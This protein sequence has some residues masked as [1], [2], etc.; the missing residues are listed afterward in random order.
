MKTTQLASMKAKFFRLS[1][2]SFTALFGLFNAGVHAATLVFSDDF[3]TAN[4]AWQ[5]GLTDTQNNATA[6]SASYGKIESGLLQLKANVGPG[7]DY[8][9]SW[10]VLNQALPANYEISYQMQKTEWSGALWTVVS[11]AGAFDLTPYPSYQF[12][13][14]GNTAYALDIAISPTSDLIAP[15]ADSNFNVG[16]WYNYKIIK[17]GQH[18]ETYVN[19]ILQHSTNGLPFDGGTLEFAAVQAGATVNIDNLQVIDTAPEPGACV[20]LSIG[21]ASLISH[22][23]KRRV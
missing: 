16:I 4:P 22:S 6:I 8:L 2:F 17:S 15:A 7:W 10:A 9:F 11:G 19:G 21:V 1:S 20:L 14:A 18:L 3:S 12:A 23:R 5:F 13:E